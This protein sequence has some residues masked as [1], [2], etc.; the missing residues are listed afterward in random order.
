MVLVL[1]RCHNLNLLQR[2]LYQGPGFP[3]RTSRNMLVDF[4]KFPRVGGPW[5]G[6][7]KTLYST[8][9]CL[10]LLLLVYLLSAGLRAWYDAVGHMVG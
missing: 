5:F 2:M 4:D 10:G 8:I 3:I 1:G 7:F 9:K 6:Y